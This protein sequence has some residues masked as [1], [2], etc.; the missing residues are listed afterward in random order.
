[1][2]SKIEGDVCLSA[3]TT[4]GV[5]CDYEQPL[6]G[7][8]SHDKRPVNLAPKSVALLLIIG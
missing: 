6:T 1:M 7:A 4:T 5:F 8:P 3:Q 2:L